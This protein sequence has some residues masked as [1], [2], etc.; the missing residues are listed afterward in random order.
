MPALKAYLVENRGVILA[1]DP[2]SALT[3]AQENG[4]PEA[5]SVTRLRTNLRVEAWGR[6]AAISWYIRN[7]DPQQLIPFELCRRDV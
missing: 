4:W 7:L 3:Y 1:R 6:T 2:T 5:R